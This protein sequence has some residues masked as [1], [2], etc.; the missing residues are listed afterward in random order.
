MSAY[1]LRHLQALIG[2]LGRL[3]RAPL[4]SILTVTL[5]GVALALPSALFVMV[6]N[7]KRLSAVW[8]GRPQIS[9]FLSLGLAEADARGIAETIRQRRDVEDVRFVSAASSFDEF[10]ASSGLGA[11]LDVLGDNPLPAVVVVYPAANAQDAASLSRIAEELAKLRHVEHAQL[12]LEWVRRLHAIVALFER[13]VLLLA[14]LLGVAVALIVSNTTRLAVVDRRGEIELVDCVGGTGAFIRRPFLYAGAL[15]GV[16][17]GAL[18]WGMV[19]GAV[20]LL[21]APAQALSASYGGTFSLKGMGVVEGFALVG[22]GGAL[23]WVGAR[24]AV[25]WQLRR[26][27]PA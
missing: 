21:A 20:V 27:R 18:A 3:V 12:D 26:L 4:P 6:D 16:L 13:A 14:G 24:V 22:I 17:G 10:K 8:E 7:I 9:A 1:L 15:Q 5:L 23:G 11:T 25:G 2:C 19:G